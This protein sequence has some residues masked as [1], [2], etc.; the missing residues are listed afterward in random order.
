[1]HP[2]TQGDDVVRR[3][4]P[5]ARLGIASSTLLTALVVGCSAE[6]SPEPETPPAASQEEPTS[7]PEPEASPAF[8]L[9]TLE[10]LSTLSAEEITELASITVESVSVDGEI[11]WTK[12]V[13]AFNART[14]VMINSGTTPEELEDSYINGLEP[15]EVAAQKYDDAFMSGLFDRSADP[16]LFENNTLRDRHSDVVTAAYSDY[17]INGET[18]VVGGIETVAVVVQSETNE[19]ALLDIN[20]RF[21]DN[22]FSS[23]ALNPDDSRV[24]GSL[25]RSTDLDQNTIQR[26][27]VAIIDGKLL[28]Q[29]VDVRS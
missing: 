4:L 18:D 14:S 20:S 27:Y 19:G 7:A 23:G 10:E 29:S 11:D 3:K 17:L 28:V 13:D 22:F 24:T 16:S 21:Y 9:I 5:T 6:P 8:G 15:R 2:G 12:Y 1:M 26:M 25:G